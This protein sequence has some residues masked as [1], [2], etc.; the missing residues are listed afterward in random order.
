[1][2]GMDDQELDLS[3]ALNKN[4]YS[5]DFLPVYLHQG[6]TPKYLIQFPVL[7]P[8]ELPFQNGLCNTIFLDNGDA[9][10]LHY[11][12]V[13]TTEH[14]HAGIISKKAMSVEVCKTRVEMTY[15][16]S[17]DLPTEEEF[18]SNIFDVL[19]DCLNWMIIAYK[20][21]KKDVHVHEVSREMFEF[22]SISRV[23]TIDS[24]EY[25][26]GIFLTNTN[27]KYRKEKLSEEDQYEVIR[28]TSV[29]YKENNPFIVSEDLLLTARHN[30]RYGFYKEAVLFSQS[31]IETFLHALFHQLLETEGKTEE[32]ITKKLEDVSFIGMVK[33][34]F[35]GRIGGVWNTDNLLT[36]IGEWYE[37]TYQLRNRVAHAGFSPVFEEAEKSIN[38]AMKF[39]LFVINQLLTKKKLYNKI[40]DYFH[41]I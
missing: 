36:P 5:D 26:A 34:E 8:F 6:I 35:H 1:M 19:V 17:S 13:L 24:W 30:F 22:A 31:F 20:L 21:H 16:L 3:F 11:S 40:V 37:N 15:V 29:I 9:C 14:I 38:S 33:K 7:L 10:T 41:L 32:E 4:S 28:Y 25:N 12:D 39:R 27:I 18:L 23:I 2:S